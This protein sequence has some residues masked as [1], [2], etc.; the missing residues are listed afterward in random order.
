MSTPSLNMTGATV[1]RDGKTLLGPIDLDLSDPGITCVM[2]ANGAG[3]SLFLRLAHGL[4]A[5]QTGTV[6]WDRVAAPLTVKDRGFVFQTPPILRRSVAA[7]I[8]F[9]LR[10]DGA[11]RAEAAVRVAALLDLVRL[12]DR[13]RIPAAQLSGGERQR[14]ALAR[15]LA[16]DPKVVLMDEPSASLDPASTK[17][18]EDLVH[19]VS[20]RGVKVIFST[21]DI[22]Q[23]RRLAADILFFDGGALAE[24][25]PSANFFDRPGSAAA[26]NYLRGTL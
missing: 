3:K 5:P 15:A 2:G 20:A 7:N 14:M 8:A 26:V 9:P 18:L 16:L 13:A 24:Q 23:A 6:T 10:A 4:L 1:R 21:H 11:G 12:T 17:A 25:A 19:D 22:G